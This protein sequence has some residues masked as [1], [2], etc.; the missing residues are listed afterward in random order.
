MFY[1]SAD[2]QREID[3]DYGLLPHHKVSTVFGAG[4]I[5]VF[6]H[7][8]QQFHLTQLNSRF[9]LLQYRGKKKKVCILF[10]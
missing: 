6:L 2:Y 1:L 5:R 8:H 3:G 4:D 7:A 9:G 10:S